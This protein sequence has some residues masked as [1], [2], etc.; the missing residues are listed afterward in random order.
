M[1]NCLFIKIVDI[2]YSLDLLIRSTS[3]ELHFD[4]NRDRPRMNALQ[5]PREQ[6]LLKLFNVRLFLGINCSLYGQ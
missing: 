2:N 5:W 1:L 4:L 6:L 3:S